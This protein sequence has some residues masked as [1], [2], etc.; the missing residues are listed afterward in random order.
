MAGIGN[1]M[2]WPCLELFIILMLIFKTVSEEIFLKTV[3]AITE[4]ENLV[5]VKFE[6]D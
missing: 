5:R 4:Q 3:N 6:R 1:K 2:L